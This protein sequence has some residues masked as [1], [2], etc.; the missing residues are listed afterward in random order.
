MKLNGR[1]I[2]EGMKTWNFFDAKLK[3]LTVFFNSIL[4]PTLIYLALVGCLIIQLFSL[5]KLAWSCE[6]FHNEKV[7]NPNFFQILR[8]FGPPPSRLKIVNIVSQSRHQTYYSKISKLSQRLH[9]GLKLWGIILWTNFINKH[10]VKKCS[11]I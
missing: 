7:T 2:A 9:I 4:S 3:G 5:I 8:M 1:E 10:M 11:I 6:M